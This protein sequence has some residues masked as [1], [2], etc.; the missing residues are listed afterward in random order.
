MIL[1][2]PRL[3][4]GDTI[5]IISPGSY[6]ANKDRFWEGIRYLESRGFSVVTARH[7]LDEYG[8]LAGRDQDRVEDLEAMFLDPK[9]KAIFCSRGGY[10]T[11]RILT[12]INY[13]VI[14]RNPKIV[15]GY[16]DIT[17]LQL[18]LLAKAELMTFSGPMVAIEMGA[19]MSPFTETNFWRLLTSDEKIGPL[20][21]PQ[22][23]EIKV[24]KKG[25]AKGRLIAGCI[26]VLTGL[27]GTHYLPALKEC[28]LV[29]EEVDE[30]PYRI[31]RYLMQLRLSGILE[32]INGL[33]FG[34]FIDCV[35]KDKQKP[36]LTVEEIID[37]VTA[38][39]KIPVIMG[40]AYGHSEEK[41]TLPIGAKAC[42][43]TEGGGLEILENVV[44]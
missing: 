25:L 10:G 39:L 27:V 13:E 29:I 43:D 14:K 37:Q 26:S 3:K 2:P 7:V 33:V 5:G 11:P 6:P 36:T 28:I 42:L 24:I 44:V 21:N 23:S 40:L 35:P 4:Q 38:D 19:G 12:R 31:D 18:A 8:Y 16:S 30:E 9:V 15:V 34:Q 20:R 32:N 22:D 17:A 41:L 1:K